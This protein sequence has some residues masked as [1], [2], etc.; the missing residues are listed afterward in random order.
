MNLVDELLK[1]V[2][3]LEGAGIAYAL[4][5][6]IAVTLHG[7]VRATKDID[8]L[9]RAEDVEAILGRLLPLGWRYVAFPMTFDAG[10]S[11]ERR[12]QRVSRIEAGRVLTLDLLIASE[13]YAQAWATRQTVDVPGG[14]LSIVSIEGLLA[15][16]RI[17]GRPQDLADIDK[18][19]GGDAEA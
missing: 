5:G 7:H 8:I 18:L 3:V 12:V 16:K 6:G 14:R 1:I 19:G 4:C 13:L 17:A 15:M 2:A 10:T 9:V 11:K